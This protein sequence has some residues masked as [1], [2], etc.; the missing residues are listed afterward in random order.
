MIQF[1]VLLIIIAFVYGF[2]SFNYLHRFD[3]HLTLWAN[4]WPRI[5]F[6]SLPMV[7][8]ALVLKRMAVSDRTKL[9]LWIIIYSIIFN[10]TAWIHVWPIALNGR[11]EVL[12]YVNSANVY[13]FAFTFLTVAPPVRYLIPFTLILVLIFVFPLFVVAYLAGDPVI[14]RLLVNDSTATI[15]SGACLSAIIQGVRMRLAAI[16]IERE[17]EARKFLGP[18]VSSAIYEQNRGILQEKTIKGFTVS[19]DICGSTLLQNE[20]RSR[21]TDFHK[22]FSRFV[23]AAVAKH[24]GYIQKTVGDR[25][26]ISFGVLDELVEASDVRGVGT[27][28]PPSADARLRRVSESTFACIDEILSQIVVIGKRFIPERMINARAGVDRGLLICGISGEGST[29]LEFDI[30]GVPVNCSDRLEKFSKNY[31]EKNPSDGS[32]LVISPSA[33]DY[34]GDLSPFKRVQLNATSGVC[35]AGIVVKEFPQIQWVL[36][37][38]YALTASPA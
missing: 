36:I 11:P 20:Y 16:E 13:L 32:I 30:N 5:V 31:L 1:S 38:N 7:V 21:W 14:F 3:P 9:F 8:S 15:L 2:T 6:S 35:D 26:V 12:S 37:K 33:S 23:R 4:V 22:E 34:M 28:S 17:D 25:Y 19:L 29:G 27:E 10:F 24:K 18:I